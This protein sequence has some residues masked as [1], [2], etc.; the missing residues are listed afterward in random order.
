MESI[1]KNPKYFEQPDLF[2]PERYIDEKDGKLIHHPII[3]SIFGFGIFHFA[4]AINMTVQVQLEVR[5]AY[6]YIHGVVFQVNGFAWEKLW[7][8]LR[9]SCPSRQL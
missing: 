1:L 5:M 3:A 6:Y 9:F 2:K 4:K 7:L 8:K